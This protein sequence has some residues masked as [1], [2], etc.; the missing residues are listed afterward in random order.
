MLSKKSNPILTAAH[1]GASTG[2]TGHLQP[3][4]SDVA[5]AEGRLFCVFQ[6]CVPHSSTLQVGGKARFASQ[7]NHS[8]V[9]EAKSRQ[10]ERQNPFIKRRVSFLFGTNPRL[11]IDIKISDYPRRLLL[12]IRGRR[13]D[14]Q[15]SDIHGQND[16]GGRNRHCGRE[17]LPQVALE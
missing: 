2:K 4:A 3:N 13:M 8:Q 10:K 17:L 5:D 11:K 12:K 7:N 15:E 14:D 1:A 9:Q 6:T 16:T